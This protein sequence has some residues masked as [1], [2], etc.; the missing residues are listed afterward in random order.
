MGRLTWV[1][2]LDFLENPGDA[3]Y[4]AVLPNRQTAVPDAAVSDASA[5]RKSPKARMA[6]RAE[7]IWGVHA[8][9]EFTPQKSI[10]HKSKG[11]TPRYRYSVDDDGEVVDMIRTKRKVPAPFDRAIGSIGST[12]EDSP[13]GFR[14][15]AADA[16]S[17]H[18]PESTESGAMSLDS[19]SAGRQ[20]TTG[21]YLPLLPSPS[22]PP[23]TISEPE[24]GSQVHRSLATG[25]RNLERRFDRMR[26][27]EEK[28]GRR[29]AAAVDA[30]SEPSSPLLPL[31][32]AALSFVDE[33]FLYDG[34]YV[35][36]L[37]FTY[38][39]LLLL[40][41]GQNCKSANSF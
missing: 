6:E 8:T 39:V 16:R 41:P 40:P 1:E 4:V 33:D 3:D 25:G 29:L 22:S 7:F 35:W 17:R 9:S 24:T 12:S 34:A 13:I 14:V 37:L 36:E 2:L 21:R 28:A 20:Q 11:L 18:H 32:A 31:S 23:D 27:A 15:H 30:L 5:G 38:D 10:T 19:S 26:G